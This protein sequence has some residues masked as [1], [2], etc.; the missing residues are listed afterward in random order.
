MLSKITKMRNF[1]SNYEPKYFGINR[2]P[3]IPPKRLFNDYII[4]TTF[5]NIY[6]V[7]ERQEEPDTLYGY[8]LKI[9]HL[10]KFKL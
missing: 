9:K 2:I 5:K 4:S 10:D 3:L 6:D 8:S 1:R 7:L